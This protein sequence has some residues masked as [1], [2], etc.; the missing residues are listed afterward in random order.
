MGQVS[1]P[2]QK[3]RRRLIAARGMFEGLAQMGTGGFVASYRIAKTEEA[4]AEIEQHRKQTQETCGQ[5]ATAWRDYVVRCLE[6]KPADRERIGAE[7]TAL[8]RKAT[9]ARISG[10]SGQDDGDPGSEEDRAACLRFFCVGLVRNFRLRTRRA[11]PRSRLVEGDAADEAAAAHGGLPLHL[12]LRP[13]Q[14]SRT[15]AAPISSDTTV[16]EIT[17]VMSFDS[18][19]FSS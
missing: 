16:R 6:V 5:I 18:R 19:P 11:G 17:A 9:N 10:C 2:W 3:E 8:V 15:T 12:L 13:F 1:L 7:M 14:P 4:A